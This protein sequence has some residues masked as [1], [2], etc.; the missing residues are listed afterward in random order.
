[1]PDSVDF[2]PLR[3]M[4]AQD[5][6]AVMQIEV[7]AYPF[8][9]TQGIFLDCL[10]HGYSCWVYEQESVMIGYA[11]VMFTLDEMHL[12]NICIR[13]EAQG[14]GLG[15]RMLRTLERV[16]RGVK[17]E[18]CFLEVRQS[19]FSAIRLYMNA[20]FNE[21][22]LRKNY[23]PATAGREDAIVMAKMLF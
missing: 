14:T 23:Y 2:L 6:D 21:V 5:L 11:V 20:G 12:L 18:T 15:S 22:G 19:N 17:A 8:P 9:W 16:A 10:K 4:T 7:C 13:P 3:P 1:M